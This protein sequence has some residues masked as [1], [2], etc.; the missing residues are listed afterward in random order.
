MTPQEKNVFGKLFTKTE[1]GTHNVELGISQDLEK[2]LS[3]LKS[4]NTPVSQNI[5]KLTNLDKLIKDEKE[6][7]KNNLNK[8][9]STYEKAVSLVDKLQQTSK[10]LGIDIPILKTANTI[11][12]GA[13]E[14]FVDLNGILKRM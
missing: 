12:D 9:N 14:D 8:L 7:S 6:L 11:L 4:L 2:L 13:A 5:D 1:L 3:E 10:D